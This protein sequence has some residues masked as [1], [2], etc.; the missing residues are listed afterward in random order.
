MMLAFL[1]DQIQEA[2]CGLFQKALADRK[3]RRAFWEKMKALF[4]NYYIDSW[5]D[6]FTAMSPGFKGARLVVDTS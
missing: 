1:I 2:A 4:H 3:T 6:L 5:E